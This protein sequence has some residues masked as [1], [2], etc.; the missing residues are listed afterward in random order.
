MVTQYYNKCNNQDTFFLRRYNIDCST[1]G[2]TSI[3]KQEP[4]LIGMFD[5]LGRPVTYVRENELV[6]YLYSDGTYKKIIRN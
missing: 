5:V 3:T 1:T 4:K 6:I 2:I